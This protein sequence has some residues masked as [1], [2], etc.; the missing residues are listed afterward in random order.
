[1]KRLPH[2]HTRSYNQFLLGRA[3]VPFSW[4]SNDCALFCADGILAQTGTDIADEFRGHYRD[5]AGAL[6]TIKAITGGTTVADAVAWCAAKHGMAELEHPLQAQR[7]DL[8]TVEDSGNEVA[9]LVHLN[10]RDVAVVG[11]TGLHRVS[12][13]KILRAWRIA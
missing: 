13:M 5:E 3:K 8:V 11:Q 1:M 9:G 10:G 4:G 6:A 7:G 2:S 12:I